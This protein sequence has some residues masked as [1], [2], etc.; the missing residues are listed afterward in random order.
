MIPAAHSRA[1]H[2][3]LKIVLVRIGDESGL[4]L[5]RKLLRAHDY[6]KMKHLAVDLVILNERAASYVQDFQNALSAL[7]R[8]NRSRPEMTGDSVRG[9]IFVLRADLVTNEVRDLLEAVARAVLRG[10][11]GSLAEQV[12]SGA[13]MMVARR[14]RADGMVQ[15]GGVRPRADRP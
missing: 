2:R 11:R 4:P 13:I 12:M 6:W 9:S 15:R 7:A 5:V 8:S 14:S 10:N 1:H 3:F